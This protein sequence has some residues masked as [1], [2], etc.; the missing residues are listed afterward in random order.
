MQPQ[1]SWSGR[2]RESARV[3]VRAPIQA[4][5]GFLP[6]ALMRTL[7]ARRLRAAIAH[8]QSYVPY[9][10]ETLRRLGLDPRDFVTAGDLARLPVIERDQLQRDPEYFVST[11]QPLACH[12]RLQ[13]GGSTGEP[14]TVFRDS[15]PGLVPGGL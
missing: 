13:S 9:Y 1:D 11:A 3:G 14:V 4:R 2:A 10:R 6:P 12:V 5:M 15:R 8:A 7:Q